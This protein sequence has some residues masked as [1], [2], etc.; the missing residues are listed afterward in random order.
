MEKDKEK[1]D[2]S[3]YYI[4]GIK[5]FGYMEMRKALSQFLEEVEKV[6]LLLR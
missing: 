2:D 6:H 4:R 5:E 1:T 3:S